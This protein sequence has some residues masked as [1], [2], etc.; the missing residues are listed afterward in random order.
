MKNIETDWRVDDTATTL[1]RFALLFLRLFQLRCCFVFN[2]FSSPGGIHNRRQYLA[3]LLPA[4]TELNSI[5]PLKL[6]IAIAKCNICHNQIFYSY[7]LVYYFRKASFASQRPHWKVPCGVLLLE[8][9]MENGH[10]TWS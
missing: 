1:F 8:I 5:L 6:F 9:I 3:Y 2:L 7:P 4:H 10:G